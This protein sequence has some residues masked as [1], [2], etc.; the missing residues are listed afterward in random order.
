MPSWIIGANNL[1]TLQTKNNRSLAM[2][3]KWVTDNRGP[4]IRRNRVNV[5]NVDMQ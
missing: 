3:V 5:P 4:I 2:P 1:K